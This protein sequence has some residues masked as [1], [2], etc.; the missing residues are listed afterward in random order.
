MKKKFTDLIVGEIGEINEE[1][2]KEE[3][4]KRIKILEI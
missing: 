3:N 4:Q 1:I 2:R